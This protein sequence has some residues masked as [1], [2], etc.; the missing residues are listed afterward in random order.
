MVDGHPFA[1]INAQ[2]ARR[3]L[4]IEHFHRALTPSTGDALLEGLCT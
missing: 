2:D 1:C 3:W 4:G